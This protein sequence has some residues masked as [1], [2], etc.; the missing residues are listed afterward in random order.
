MQNLSGVAPRL[1]NH[2]SDLKNEDNMNITELAKQHFQ[3]DQQTYKGLDKF[4][5]DTLPK[6]IKDLYKE[7]AIKR[8]EEGY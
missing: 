1:G 6:G 2:L 8:E 4:T 7:A 5:W 3:T